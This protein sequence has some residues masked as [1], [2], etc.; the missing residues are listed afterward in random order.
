M[1]VKLMTLYDE[2]TQR[3]QQHVYKI[4]LNRKYMSWTRI[5]QLKLNQSEMKLKRNERFKTKGN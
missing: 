2:A 5:N 1:K 3:G 4:K